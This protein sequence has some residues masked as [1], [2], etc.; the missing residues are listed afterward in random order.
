VSPSPRRVVVTAVG[1]VFR[2]D[3][4]AGPAVL[5]MARPCLGH[6]EVVRSLSSPF[7]LVGTWDGAELAVVVDALRAGGPAGT[8]HVVEVCPEEPRAPALRSSRTSSHGIGVVEVLR[9]SRACGTAPRRVLLVGVTGEE[10]GPG[11]GL[12]PTVA[13]A[14][15]RAAEVVVDAVSGTIDPGQANGHAAHCR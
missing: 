1:S 9:L 13:Q 5:D 2:H 7:D 6:V 12:S 4:G 8:V 14:V 11:V 15:A 10:F 3:D